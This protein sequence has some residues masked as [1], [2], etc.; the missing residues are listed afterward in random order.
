MANGAPGNGRGGSDPLSEDFE[1]RLRRAREGQR[2][3]EPQAAPSLLGL[4]F[5]LAT[6][7]V[8]AVAVGFA[9]GWLLDRWLGTTPWLMLVFFALGSAAGF[10][11]VVR[12]ARQM[13][14]QSQAGPPAPPA[15]E[16]DED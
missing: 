2:Q 7:L 14:I 3:E 10:V 13:N 9:L 4:A 16:D 8:V 15:T 6:E 1:E 5:R 11:N 12:T